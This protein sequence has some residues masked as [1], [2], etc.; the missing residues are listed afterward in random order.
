M[1]CDLKIYLFHEFFC[2]WYL[3][4]ISIKDSTSTEILINGDFE[5]S[6]ST[7]GWTI[8][9]SAALCS[10]SSGI[11]SSRF[12][13]SNKSYYDYCDL[14]TTWIDQSFNV[15]SGQSYNISFWFYVDRLST[16]WTMTNVY[17]SVNIVWFIPL[18]IED[19]NSFIT[20]SFLY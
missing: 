13:S 2:V 12:H 6:P 8:D 19:I 4:D 16:L 11:S 17:M 3:D 20:L 14:A 7:I 5:R 18:Y 10:L 1:T 15:T 9:Y